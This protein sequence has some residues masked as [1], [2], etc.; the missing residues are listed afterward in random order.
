M[1]KLLFFICIF[2]ISSYT[3][4]QDIN[5]EIGSQTEFVE[6]VQNSKSSL[7]LKAI[8]WASTNTTEMDVKIKNSDKEIG[9]LL[10]TVTKRIPK[11]EG[12]NEY[13]FI[14]VSMNVKIDCRD[15]KFRVMFSNFIS[16]T[17]INTDA[18]LR[19][20][21]SNTLQKMLKEL[22]KVQWLGEM[23][24]DN[25]LIWECEKI[26]EVKDLYENRN[27]RKRT[28]ISQIDATTKKGEREIKKI[29]E[30]IEENDKYIGHLTYIL[31]SIGVT[32][33]DVY[34]SI[35]KELITPDDF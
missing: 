27:S 9:T 25:S 3:K 18:D 7:F 32:V 6:T 10:L 15:N 28:D 20:L 30:S 16:K 29:R 12:I 21:P 31:K 19:Y 4:G 17:L 35:H 11:K 1:K 14:D 34:Y 23:R 24:F 22:E 5:K 2:S 26:I 8:T 13:S 33:K